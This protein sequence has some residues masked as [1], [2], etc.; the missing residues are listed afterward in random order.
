MKNSKSLRTLALGAALLGLSVMPSSVMAAPVSQSGTTTTTVTMPE[1]L[2]LHY[3]SAVALNFSATSSSASQ[4]GSPLSA[5]WTTLGDTST[6]LAASASE[7]GP[8]SANITLKNA[9]AIAGLSSSG[10]A[11]VSIT[12]TDFSATRVGS[13]SKIGVTGYGLAS[14]NG[15]SGAVTGATVTTLLRGVTGQ[16]QTVG[17]VKM[18]LNFSNTTESGAHAGSFTITAQTI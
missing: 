2:V 8:T 9:W 11:T 17:D 6:T 13:T 18:T 4:T 14:T 1:Y 12:G 3:Y 16:T 10:T 5:T 15:V 7:V